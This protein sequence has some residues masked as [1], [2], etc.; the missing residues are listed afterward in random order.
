MSEKFGLEWQKYDYERVC[1]LIAVSDAI[2][3]KSEI[4]ARKS[5][6][7]YQHGRR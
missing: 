7:N 5:H 1:Y 2:S 6:K 3:E 4:E